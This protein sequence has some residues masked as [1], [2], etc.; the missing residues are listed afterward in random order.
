LILLA[1][2]LI[3]SR[4]TLKGQLVFL[5]LSRHFPSLALC[6]KVDLGLVDSYVAN[7]TVKL[8][9]TNPSSHSGIVFSSKGEGS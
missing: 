7:V 6:E 2:T 4:L 8:L 3:V 1:E 5:L 9:V